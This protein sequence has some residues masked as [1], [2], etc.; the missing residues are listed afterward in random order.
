MSE[1]VGQRRL[2]YN[3]IFIFGMVF[4]QFFG[5]PWIGV[6]V[7]LAAVRAFYDFWQEE[8]SGSGKQP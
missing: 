5:W 6:A 3:I 7:V 4:G 8:R 2:T 1:S